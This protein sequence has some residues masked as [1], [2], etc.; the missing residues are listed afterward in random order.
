MPIIKAGNP[1]MD[2]D[3]S[4]RADCGRCAGLCCIALAFDRSVLFTADKAAGEPCRHLSQADRCMIHAK[5]AASGYAGCVTYDCQGAGQL[6]TQDLFGGRSWRDC[7][8]G[9]RAMFRAFALARRVQHWRALL[10][11]AIGLPLT[12]PLARRRAVLAARLAP[13]AGWTLETLERAGN[14][15]AGEMSDFLK[16]LRTVT[17]RN[18]PA[19]PASPH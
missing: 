7:A 15:S 13:A 11:A 10:A 9:G 1:I 5:R 2:E 16:A 3:A 14:G 6:V 18:G 17:P 12:P 19:P 4:L 8:D